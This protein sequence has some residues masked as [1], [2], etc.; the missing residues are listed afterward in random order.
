MAYNSS[1]K[2]IKNAYLTLT[3]ESFPRPSNYCEEFVMAY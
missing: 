2:A 1:T 3:L